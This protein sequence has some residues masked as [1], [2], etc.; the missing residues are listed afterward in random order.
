M[1]NMPRIMHILPVKSQFSTAKY[2][3]NRLGEL[4]QEIVYS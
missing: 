3:N 4:Y 1:S 2:G